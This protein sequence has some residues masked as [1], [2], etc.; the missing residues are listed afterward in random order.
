MKI[1]AFAA[2]NSRQSINRELARYAASLLEGEID[3]LDLN[4]FEMPLLSVDYEAEHGQPQAAHDFLAVL[5]SADFIVVSF[6]EHNGNYSA[7]YKNIFDWA[8]RIKREVYAGKPTLVLATS[9]GA[10]GG[11]SVLALA[12]KQLPHFGA[13]VVGQFSLPEFTKNFDSSAGTIS[14]HELDQQLR[15]VVAAIK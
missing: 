11:A 1:V 3:L 8:T 15:D 5:E 13:N 9:P 14:N 10:R 6:A 2:S 12:E 4:D 7:A